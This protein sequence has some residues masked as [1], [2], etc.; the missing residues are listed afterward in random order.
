MSFAEP[1]PLI[2]VDIGNSRIKLGEFD[3]PPQSGRLPEPNR[4]LL[5][6][7]ADW[8]PMEI[9][10]WLAPTSPAAINWLLATV[11][12]PA[13]ARLGKW[14]AHEG[15]NKTFRKLT[16]RDLPLTV[17]IAA[18]QAVGIDRLLGAVAAN[19][20]RRPELPALI[21]DLGSA[22]TVDLVSENGTFRGGAIL[23]GIGMGARALAEF[24]DLLPLVDMTG[25]EEPPEVLGTLTTGA[26]SSGL[27]WGALGAIRELI[28]RLSAGLEKEP[29]VF[30]TGNAAPEMA[31]LIDEQVCFEPHLVLAGIVL[32]CL[33]P[34]A[35]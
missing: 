16:H 7:T 2:A 9:A 24:T 15:G 23:P 35:E 21:I 34:A 13:S 29:Q 25:L 12:H 17:D 33:A 28:G 19:F 30:L 26:I 8:A 1:F 22:I 27:Y 4:T 11:N 5:L 20:L 14:L 10:L 18:P 3:R 32:A 31:R 6:D